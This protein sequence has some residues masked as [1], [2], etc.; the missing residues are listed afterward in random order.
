[1]SQLY[2]EWQNL[3]AET[4][5]KQQGVGFFGLASPKKTEKKIPP[6]GDFIKIPI[7]KVISGQLTGVPPLCVSPKLKK[8]QKNFQLTDVPPTLCLVWRRKKCT[9]W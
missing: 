9:S 4:C 3:K 5:E 6:S 2:S 7:Y 1:M 8:T